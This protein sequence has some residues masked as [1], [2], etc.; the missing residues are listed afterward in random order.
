MAA[1]TSRLLYRSHLARGWFAVL[2][3]PVVGIS[4]SAAS[5]Q[6]FASQVRLT[7]VC[8]IH[9]CRS[10]CKVAIFSPSVI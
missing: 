2:S 9:P 4:G 5:A 8:D 1:R 6:A 10:S 3:F 7:V